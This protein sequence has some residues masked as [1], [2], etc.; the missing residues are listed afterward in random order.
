[1]VQLVKCMQTNDTFWGES[2]SEL[3][4]IRGKSAQQDGSDEYDTLKPLIY[5]FASFE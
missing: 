3:V 5:A 1:M 2:K 4:R